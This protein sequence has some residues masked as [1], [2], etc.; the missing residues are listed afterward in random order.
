MISADGQRLTLKT[1]YAVFQLKPDAFQRLHL[2]LTVL[3]SAS[4]RQAQSGQLQT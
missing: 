3:Y 4:R 2:L 1:F